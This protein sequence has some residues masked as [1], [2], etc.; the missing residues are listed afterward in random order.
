[1]VKIFADTTSSIPVEQARLLGIVYLPQIIVFGEQ[2]YRDDTELDTAAFLQKL[3]AATNLPKTAAPPPAFYAPFY[4]QAIEEGDDVLV[5]CPSSKVS[6]TVRSAETAAQE[7]PQKKIRIVDT[8]TVGSGLASIVLQALEWAKQG[9]DLDTLEAQVRAMAARQKVYF[10]VDTLE[11]LRKGGRIGGA[12][13]L[14]GSILQIKPILTLQDGQAA[15]VASERTRHR[16]IEHVRQ[17]VLSDCPRGDEA[18][19]AIMQGDALAEAQRY[20]AEFAQ[21][22]EIPSVPVYELPPAILVH[23]GPGVLAFSYFIE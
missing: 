3:R 21:L 8:L 11:Y 17:L 6:G 12:Q 4:R 1:M 2:S 15:P 14:L 7:F 18:H 19:F 20:A 16:A 23:A 5:I 22:L 9:L 10:V 13:A